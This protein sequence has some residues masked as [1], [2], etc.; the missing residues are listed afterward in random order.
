MFKI[1]R[2]K[3]YI[4]H[5]GVKGMKWDESKKSHK[6][7]KN[8]ERNWSENMQDMM[9]R[10]PDYTFPFNDY[11]EFRAELTEIG[12]NAEKMS[13]KRVKQLYNKAQRI[14]IKEKCK[15]VL[16]RKATSAKQN[17]LS[18]HPR[19]VASGA[20]TVPVSNKSANISGPVGN[21][22]LNVIRRRAQE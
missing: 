20:G 4:V 22:K 13:D 10:N 15:A 2:N 11:N 21:R 18:N 6:A 1:T 7:D 12:Y 8:F 17:S 16:N 9:K 3:D 5:Y 19:N 14:Y